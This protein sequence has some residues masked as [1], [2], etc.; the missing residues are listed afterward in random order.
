MNNAKG[1]G[2]EERELF[3]VYT[4]LWAGTEEKRELC[5]KGILGIAIDE[6]FEMEK[7]SSNEINER[8]IQMIQIQFLGRLNY[9]VELMNAQ[10]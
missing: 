5:R 8:I 4:W 9:P 3:S 6:I 10:D 7:G 2:K 1:I